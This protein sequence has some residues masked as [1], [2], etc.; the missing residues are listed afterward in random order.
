MNGHELN[1]KRVNLGCSRGEVELSSRIDQAVRSYSILKET[2]KL[3]LYGLDSPMVNA[4]RK[5][6]KIIHTVCV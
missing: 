4:F 5:R 2:W 6:L 3:R 1:Y